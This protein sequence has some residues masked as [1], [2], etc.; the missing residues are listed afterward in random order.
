MSYIEGH[1]RESLKG[2]FLE[3]VLDTEKFKAFYM[4]EKPNSRMM[5]TLF[6]FHPEGIT[7]AG[8]LTPA[9][10]GN[11]STIG[12]GLDWFASKL[13]ETYLC[14][15]FLTQGWHAEL[16]EEELAEMRDS[17]LAGKNDHELW[18]GLDD[19]RCSREELIEELLE[20]RRALVDA[21]P[22]EKPA[23]RAAIRDMRPPLIAARAAIVAKREEVAERI[24]TLLNN[25]SQDFLY[26]E[27]TSYFEHDSE[28]MPGYGYSPREA[29]WL[30][31][32]QQKFSELYHASKKTVPEE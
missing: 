21:E 25:L 12:Y 1:M 14:E 7:I 3:M 4:R 30:C 2:H 19:L 32:L 11:C 10:H 5:S 17:T 28:G 18:G 22:D 23:I 31:A 8:D 20:Y 26:E 6:I 24:D 9:L 29:G 27:W 13:S 16:A 15:K